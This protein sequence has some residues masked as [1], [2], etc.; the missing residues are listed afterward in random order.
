MTLKHQGECSKATK[1]IQNIANNKN[2]YL[3]KKNSVGIWMDD[4]NSQFLFD[5]VFILFGNIFNP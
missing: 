1:Q 2:C 3:Q 5:T 4:R